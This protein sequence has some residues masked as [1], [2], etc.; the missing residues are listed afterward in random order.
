MSTVLHAESKYDY[1][2]ERKRV[3]LIFVL[4]C[5]DSP[6]HATRR[7]V[8]AQLSLVG[9]PVVERSFNFM[10]YDGLDYERNHVGD[11]QEAEV[12]WDQVELAANVVVSI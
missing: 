9:V 1:K 10:P 3:L 2:Y 5:L 7:V 8:S 11:E 6:R 12:C 4:S